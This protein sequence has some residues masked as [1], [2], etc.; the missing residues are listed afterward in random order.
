MEKQGPPSS[1]HL[2]TDAPLHSH[3]LLEGTESNPGLGKMRTQHHSHS[4]SPRS[5]EVL[6]L[7]SSPLEPTQ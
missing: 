6:P 5:A 2:D 3:F 4:K 1:P 7:G